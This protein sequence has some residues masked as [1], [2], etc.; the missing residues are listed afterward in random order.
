MWWQLLEECFAS[1]GCFV[2]I[3]FTL[4][5]FPTLNFIKLKITYTNN[6]AIWRWGA[7]ALLSPPRAC[8]LIY[9][10]GAAFYAV[11]QNGKGRHVQNSN[12]Q[13]FLTEIMRVALLLT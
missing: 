8:V 2:N 5:T 6:H 13:I 12:P 3:L 4:P 9:N 1:S 7:P 10:K 11:W